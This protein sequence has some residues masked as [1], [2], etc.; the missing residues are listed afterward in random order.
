MI[1][2]KQTIFLLLAAIASVLVFF[3]PLASFIGE[4][5]SFVM[6]VHQ[7]KSLVPDTHSPYSL[8]FLLPLV[9]G[10]AFVIL[11][12]L[13][14]IFLYKNRKA[15]MKITKLNILLEVLFIGLFFLYYVDVL[16][17]A[18]GATAKYGIGVF[19]PMISLILLVFAYR[20]IVQDERL[21]RSADRL[22]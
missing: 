3:F 4:K 1:Q 12:S 19:M 22:R 13:L 16:E 20:G 2:R 5:G 7:I 9:L 8:N 6:F 11:F 10:N 17:K 14:T 15:Q 21:V 18:S